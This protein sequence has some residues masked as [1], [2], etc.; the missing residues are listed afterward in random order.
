MRFTSMILA[1]SILVAGF[2]AD[3]APVSNLDA[4]DSATMELAIE[5]RLHR[6]GRKDAH[7]QG[8]HVQRTSRDEL[9]VR[10]EIFNA[11]REE[12]AT[13]TEYFLLK[14]SESRDGKSKRFVVSPVAGSASAVSR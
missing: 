7:V 4:K 13:S 9:I 12:T 5:S 2:L 3:A 1:G 10:A 11:D 8:L 6:A 14:M